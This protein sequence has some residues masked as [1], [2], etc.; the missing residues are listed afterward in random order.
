MMRA[1][2]LL[3]NGDTTSL[4]RVKMRWWTSRWSWL[5]S[6]PNL[7]CRVIGRPHVAVIVLDVLVHALDGSAEIGPVMQL[8]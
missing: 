3:K 4:G 2:V 1:S 7:P 6:T 8:G 5:R